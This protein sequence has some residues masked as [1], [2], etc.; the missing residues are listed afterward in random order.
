[1]VERVFDAVLLDN[2]HLLVELVLDLVGL[3]AD[4]VLGGFVVRL[5]RGRVV[6]Y[7]R[8]YV[9]VVELFDAV[10]VVDVVGE[11]GGAV[12][13]EV[14]GEAGLVPLPLLQLLH[15]LEVLQILLRQQNH[16]L[17]RRHLV[18]PYPI[19]LI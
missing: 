8:D 2:G 19:L 4:Q 15:Q 14:H 10:L 6:Q 13:L 18:A 17:V 3:P 12:L 1:V 5:R 7:L 16:L 11:L 9:A